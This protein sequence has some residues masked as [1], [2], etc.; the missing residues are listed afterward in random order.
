MEE[1]VAKKLLEIVRS[2]SSELDKA[3]YH[4]RER[5]SGTERAALLM[6]IGEIYA[7]L[8]DRIESPTL[9]LYPDLKS[10]ADDEI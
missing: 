7:I 2:T 10:G 6:A 1:V 3:V 9:A 8:S 4:I 5:T